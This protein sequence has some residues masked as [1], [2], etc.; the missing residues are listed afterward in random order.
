MAHLRVG[1]RAMVV[2]SHIVKGTEYKNKSGRIL[3]ITRKLVLIDFGSAGS[4]HIPKDK[5]IAQ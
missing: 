4:H 5:V 3:M 1:G 2:E